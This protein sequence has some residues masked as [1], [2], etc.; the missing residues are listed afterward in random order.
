MGACLYSGTSALSQRRVAL[1][2]ERGAPLSRLLLGPLRGLV[3]A[4]RDGM[5]PYFGGGDCDDHNAAIGPGA[6]DVPGNGVDEDCSGGDAQ[7]VVLERSQ[8][9]PSQDDAR[10]RLP[11]DLNVV[12]LSVDALRWDVTRYAGSSR[13]LVPSIDRLAAQSVVFERAYSLASYTGKSIPPTF[14]GKYTS[15]THRGWAHFNRVDPRDILLHERL[16]RAAIRTLSV[17][18]YWYF[19]RKDVGFERGWDLLDSR[20]APL[21]GYVENDKSYSSDKVADRALEVLSD[22]AQTKGRFFLWSHFMDPHADYVAH[23]GF[24]FGRKSRDLYDSEVAFTDHHLGRVVDFVRQSPFA[25]RTAIIVF[26]DHGEA[27]GE[28]GMIRHGFELWEE[29][30]RVPWLIYLPGA[31]PHHVQARRSLV[32]LVPTVLA[33]FGLPLP[34]GQGDDFVSGQSLLPDLLGTPGSPADERIVFVDMAAGPHNAERQAFIDGNLKLVASNGRPLS[35]YD[36]AE[37]PGEKRDLLD[38]AALRARV[39]ERFRAFRRGLREV[40]VTP[41]P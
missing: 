7:P 40:R 9:A 39:V 3:D 24:D 34:A 26:S 25:A 11:S 8:P 4:D 21:L 27:F 17:Q 13:T 2:L 10:R 12:I 30:V 38:D 29:L 33:L 20:A 35:L 31:V 18:G 15:E 36:L 16:Q 37:D 22:P 23:E 19:F 32:D 5:S 6:Y 28:H 14:I 41:T 1:A